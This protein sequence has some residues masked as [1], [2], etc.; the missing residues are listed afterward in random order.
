M[1]FK[2]PLKRTKAELLH[3]LVL[4]HQRLKSN[5]EISRLIV[6]KYGL[7]IS[8]IRTFVKDKD[9]P[10]F[11]NTF[12]DLFFDLYEW[13]ERT[14][15]KELAQINP[16]AEAQLEKKLVDFKPKAGNGIVVDFTRG[17]KHV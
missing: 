9:L 10:T 6:R 12:C 4:S 11:W 15:I 16:I 1:A 7:D 5:P 2:Y 14:G 8:L 3:K 17:F 13:N